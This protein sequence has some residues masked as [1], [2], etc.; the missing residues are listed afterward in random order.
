MAFADIKSRE[1]AAASSSGVD[2]TYGQ[3]SVFG[4]A[5]LATAP[6]DEDIDCEDEQEAL[7]YLQLVRA[8]ARH[9]PNVLIAPRYGPQAFPADYNVAAA[10]RKATTSTILA[11]AAPK[12]KRR[13]RRRHWDEQDDGVPTIKRRRVSRQQA[14]T[15]ELSYDDDNDGGGGGGGASDSQQRDYDDEE[16][17]G[18]EED[19]G[20]VEDEEEQDRGLDDHAGL[21]RSIYENGVGDARGYYLDG[22][23]IAA[24]D[25]RNGAVTT[26]AVS[27]EAAAHPAADSSTDATANA[28]ADLFC[29]AYRARLLAR[30]ALL[31]S[32]LQRDPPPAAVA[33]LPPDHDVTIG[34]LSTRS[35][36]FRRALFLLQ[37]TDPLPAQIAA[38][39]KLS[40][41]RLL[42]VLLRGLLAGGTA[43]GSSRSSRSGRFARSLLGPQPGA[44]L[45]LD[46]DPR[47]SRWL[48]A[49]LARLPDRGELDYR[50]VGYIRDVAKQAVMRLAH[51]SY[52][53]GHRTGGC[54]YDD[55]G[56]EVVP[57]VHP[58]DDDGDDYGDLP[59]DDA[60]PDDLEDVAMDVESEPEQAANDE[61]KPANGEPGDTRSDPDLGEE[62]EREQEQHTEYEP[63][64]D[65][66]M[67]QRATLEMVLAVAGEFYGQRDLLA[68]RSPW[69]MPQ[70]D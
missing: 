47:T 29:A 36:A 10:V 16:E 17:D 48:W 67:H 27:A 32:H 69:S 65:V 64:E 46:M 33:A 5:G 31:R 30:F 14:V 63:E 24:P 59:E 7:A 50:E 20:E 19:E 2:Q 51:L 26:N 52:D 18:E 1:S 55:Q 45:G 35:G 42:R 44:T 25:E 39:D 21:D 22:A 62:Q 6:V 66:D 38:L 56:E 61:E 70:A 23:Y 43:E 49:L 37:T 41:F 9:I 34:P 40:A 8:E 53:M 68:F 11:A 57:P 15:V 12:A 4:G 13:R 60:L 3:R 54:G 58:D 28:D